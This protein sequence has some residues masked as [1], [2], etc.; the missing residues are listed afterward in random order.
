MVIYELQCLISLQTAFAGLLSFFIFQ[1]LL[2]REAHD[3]RTNI[4]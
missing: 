1:E 4:G 3:A 2:A